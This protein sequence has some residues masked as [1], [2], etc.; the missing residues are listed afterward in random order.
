MM[1]TLAALFGSLPIALG[2]GFGWRSAPSAGPRGRR[3]ARRVAVDYA[4][5]TPVIYT[6][7]ARMVKTRRIA[8]A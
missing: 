4:L 8:T 5:L 7:L 2:Y 1:T 3:R 6:Y